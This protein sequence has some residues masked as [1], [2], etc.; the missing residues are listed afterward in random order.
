LFRGV[1]RSRKLLPDDPVRSAVE[2]GLRY[3][4][5]TSV[6]IT[7]RRVGKGWRFLD[8]TGLT[9]RDEEVLKRIRSLVIPPAWARVWICPSPTGHLQAIGYD[10]RGRKQYRYH[11]TYSQVRNQTKF[12]RLTAFA[13]LLPQIRERVQADISKGGLPREKVLATLVRLLETTY[14]RIGNGVYAKQ[15]RSFGLTTLQNRHVEV[16]GAVIRFSFRGKSGQDHEIELH[17]R[18][19]ARVIRNCQ[20]LP[21]CELFQY[22]DTEGEQR[23]VHSEDVNGYIREAAG[24][25]F[26]AK[27]FRTWGGTVLAMQKLAEMG[28][29]ANETEAKRNLVAM[30][31]DVAESLGNRPATCRKYYIHPVLF[32][33]YSD[34]RLTALVKTGEIPDEES[35]LRILEKLT[36]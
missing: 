14:I 5:E 3:V 33:A 35:V 20:D 15:N 24:R 32:E 23:S 11:P 21:G 25:E 29:P 6:G 9:I 10:Q 17:D 8:A 1:P 28:A 16:E 12:G 18:R 26:T 34:G 36:G 27:D 4:R 31:K 30:V 13:R 19:L 22:L 2:V 7:R